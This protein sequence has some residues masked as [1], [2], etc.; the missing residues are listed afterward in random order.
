MLFCRDIKI[1]HKLHTQGSGQ[2]NAYWVKNCFLRQ[3]VHYYMVYVADCPES[4]LQVCNYPQKRRIC[5]KH[6]PIF[7]AIF[8]LVE[9][10]PTS[11]TLLS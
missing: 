9:R 5:R 8:A 4:N 6:A 10:Q 1:F 11:A 2:K 7:M 3:E